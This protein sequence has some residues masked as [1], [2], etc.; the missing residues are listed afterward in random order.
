MATIPMRRLTSAALI[1]C[2]LLIGACTRSA[3]SAPTGTPGSGTTSPLTGQQATMEAV[4]SVLLTQTAAAVQGGGP[5]IS[6][7]TPSV[8]TPVATSAALPSATRTLPPIPTLVVP[9]SYTLHEGEFP[10]CLARR[11]NR[12]PDDILAIN[13]MSNDTI[14]SPGQTLS[15]PTSGTFPGPRALLTHP[16]TYTVAGGDTIYSVGCRYGDAD[17][18]A[19]AAANGLSSPYTLT[20]G[21]T[22]QIP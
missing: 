4:R 2:G 6:T 1:A 20:P 11:F 5:G 17:P 12:N 9:A 7:A 3:S 22:I 14:V 15:I 13:G 10:Y 16:A 18:I 21:T 19:I 8:G